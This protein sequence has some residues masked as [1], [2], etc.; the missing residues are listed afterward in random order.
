MTLARPAL[1]AAL[2]ALGSTV[3]SAQEPDERAARLEAENAALRLELRLLRDRMTSIDEKLTTLAGRAPWPGAGARGPDA[4]PPPDGLEAAVSE[5]GTMVLVRE[6]RAADDAGAISPEELGALLVGV[7]GGPDAEREVDLAR[8]AAFDPRDPGHPFLV[9][10]PLWAKV[11]PDEATGAPTWGELTVVADE[12][13][14]ALRGARVATLRVTERA[15]VEAAPAPA[16]PRTRDLAAAIIGIAGKDWSDNEGHSGVKATNVLAG[17]PAA[18]AGV[19]CEDLIQT[20]TCD[21]VVHP[22]LSLEQLER[23]ISALRPGQ[24][25]VGLRRS[26]TTDW[27]YYFSTASSTKEVTLTIG[28]T[29]RAQDAKVAPTARPTRWLAIDAVGPGGALTL[30]VAAARVNGRWLVASIRTAWFEANARA[31]LEVVLG[32]WRAVRRSHEHFDDQLTAEVLCARLAEAG[33]QARAVAPALLE[34][35]GYRVSLGIDLDTHDLAAVARPASS[36]LPTLLFGPVPG[37]TDLARNPYRVRA[38]KTRT[39]N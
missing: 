19:Q 6:A 20:I 27:D 10:G 3:A 39:E 7:L 11:R 26:W 30:E 34:L 23:A 32:R 36:R 17:G 4:P 16:T 35:P 25:V 31:A 29:A 24:V 33:L 28:G 14:G 8:L 22:T 12:L 38:A 37:E 15:P 13:K 1:L 18:L 21:G 5:D 2:L 9:P